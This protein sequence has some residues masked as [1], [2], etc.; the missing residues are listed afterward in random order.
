MNFT[1]IIIYIITYLILGSAAYQLGISS[2]IAI[3]HLNGYVA[4]PWELNIIWSFILE[5]TIFCIV[6]FTFFIPISRKKD[7][8]G[9][10]EKN[11]IYYLMESMA[12]SI[13]N[14]IEKWGDSKDVRQ[15][16]INVFLFNFVLYITIIVVYAFIIINIAK[17][18]NWIKAL[19]ILFISMIIVALL[20]KIN[21]I[22]RT[23][24]I[25]EMNNISWTKTTDLVSRKNIITWITILFLLFFWMYFN[26]IINFFYW[27]IHNLVPFLDL[28][29]VK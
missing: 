9:K 19:I 21:Y 12:D 6:I 11:N 27:L 7:N 17:E 26:T 28:L 14:V 4:N 15:S 24:D 25:A 5:L 13:N 1:K 23:L 20:D 10:Q 8:T 3:T 18:A 16:A 22:I 29:R 2:Y